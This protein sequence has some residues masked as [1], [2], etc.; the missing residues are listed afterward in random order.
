MSVI[1]N[2]S[3][4]KTNYL[5]Y[6]TKYLAL[7][8]SQIGGSN[9]EI[10]LDKSVD[11]L[12][13]VKKNMDS[14]NLKFNRFS[15]VYGKKLDNNTIKNNVTEF[16]KT[17]LSNYSMIGCA[18]SHI[19]LWKQLVNSDSKAYLILEDD[20][21]LTNESVE[22]I[23]KIE[24]ILDKYSIDILNL[25]CTDIGSLFV[26]KSF[27]IDNYKFNKS[28]FPLITT[29]YII[30]KEGSNKLL[31]KI[32]K[33]SYHIDFQI[34]SINLFYADLNY[35]NSVKPLILNNHE[36]STLGNNSDSLIINILYK[37]KLN[38]IAWL[39]SNI[40][41]FTINLYY[42]INLI[43]ILLILLLLLNIFKN[44]NNI[45]ITL[46]IIL[47]LFLY[48]FNYIKNFINKS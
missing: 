5:I 43:L 9:T 12:A 27:T 6:K 35:Y 17:I 16:G 18:M 28:V 42:E 15:A 29:A 21:I 8:N 33:I 44:N 32:N 31:N 19:N 1:D 36:D 7:K 25:F 41:I 30:T 48:N 46:F 20:A 13:K 39:L 23:K 3:I 24:I 37:L 22:I 11:R 40:N 34:A 14:L 10:N 47:E 38:Y 45:I 4:Y 2:Y 26:Q